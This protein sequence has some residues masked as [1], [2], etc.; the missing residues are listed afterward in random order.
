MCAPGSL[1]L[2]SPGS[3]QELYFK[4]SKFLPSH[5][6]VKIYFSLVKMKRR[7]T[8]SHPSSFELIIFHLK[9]TSFLQWGQVILFE[10][11]DTSAWMERRILKL[12]F[13]EILKI[14][15]L[16][17]P[18]KCSC[19]SSTLDR[20]TPRELHN[21]HSSYSKYGSVFHIS[22][23]IN[24][25]F[26]IYVQ[27]TWGKGKDLRKGICYLVWCTEHTHRKGHPALFC[28]VKDCQAERRLRPY[29]P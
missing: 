12:H 7:K 20:R 4:E 23:R 25:Y 21:I 17:F 11:S 18:S 29:E 28:F 8:K 13:S 6:S 2:S 14:I 19:P 27:S 26:G 9:L 5:L 22:S 16:S 3:P 15:R 1:W 24:P 10:Q